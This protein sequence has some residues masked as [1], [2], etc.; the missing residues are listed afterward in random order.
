ME[1]NTEPGGEGQYTG[2]RG[3]TLDY[4]IRADNSFLTA[5]YTRSKF[6]AWTLGGGEEGSANYLQVIRT[7]GSKESYSAISGLTVNKDDVIRI[8]TGNGGGSGNPKDR[9]REAIRED[10]KNGLISKERTKRVYGTL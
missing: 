8:V 5:A 7:D 2:G 1:L 10:I 9:D 4:R 6:P 3:I